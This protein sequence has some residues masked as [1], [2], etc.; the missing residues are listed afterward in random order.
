MTLLLAAGRALADASST[1]DTA[2]PPSGAAHEVDAGL[3]GR[4]APCWSA[5]SALRPW[6]ALHGPVSTPLTLRSCR[7]TDCQSVTLIFALMSFISHSVL[8]FPFMVHWRWGLSPQDAG[9]V[10]TSLE[11]G[12]QLW[13][14]VNVISKCEQISWVHHRQQ[15]QVVNL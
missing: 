5:P 15:N 8:G 12:R 4:Q 2:G 10:V 1:E 3:G 11:A 13:N 6:E 9:A 14:K 7:Y